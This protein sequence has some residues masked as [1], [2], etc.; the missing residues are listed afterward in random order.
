MEKKYQNSYT[1][2]VKTKREWLKVISE[3]D[4]TRYLENEDYHEYTYVG[5]K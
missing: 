2:V 3:E 1:C 5:N 4:F